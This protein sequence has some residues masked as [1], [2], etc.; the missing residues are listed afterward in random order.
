MSCTVQVAQNESS[1]FSPYNRCWLPSDQGMIFAFVGPM[2]AIIVVRLAVLYSVLYHCNSWSCTASILYTLHKIITIASPELF[3]HV[4][5][6]TQ[7]NAILLTISLASL[8]KSQC[9]KLGDK[10]EEAEHYLE[11]GK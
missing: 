11:V 1:R 3:W 9:K 5:Y 6:A 10:K 8:A 4:I 7:V 2:I